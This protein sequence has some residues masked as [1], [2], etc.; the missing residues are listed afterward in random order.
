MYPDTRAQFLCMPD[1]HCAFVLDARAAVCRWSHE[2]LAALMSFTYFAAVNCR[3]IC[4]F[5]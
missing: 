5:A 2:L 1:H 3:V 4:G